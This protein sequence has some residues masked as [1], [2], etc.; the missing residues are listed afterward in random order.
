MI[1]ASRLRFSMSS[2]TKWTP[3]DI[4]L[5]PVGVT[6][7]GQWAVYLDNVLTWQRPT[8]TICTTP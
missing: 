5:M 6:P 2:Q 7:T 3:V 8:G 4:P 1:A